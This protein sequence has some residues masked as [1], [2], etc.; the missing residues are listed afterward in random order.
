MIPISQAEVSV[1]VRGAFRL[2][3]R[4]ANGVKYYRTDGVTLIKSFWAAAIVLPGL[5]FLDY[6]AQ[7]GIWLDVPLVRSV[8]VE[9]AGYSMMWTVWPL[10]MLY[11]VKLLDLDERYNLYIIAQ[12]WMAV[13]IVLL[14]VVLVGGAILVGQAD[15]VVGVVAFVSQM[16]A[17]Y[18]HYFVIRTTLQVSKMLA[19]TLMLGNFFL[20]VMLLDIRMVVMLGG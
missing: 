6:L 3:L 20:N 17:L 4:D 9:L 1:A 5:L 14:Y 12:N 13:P 18:C 16:W 2:F 10:L 15:G 11:L 19:A 7:S 8:I